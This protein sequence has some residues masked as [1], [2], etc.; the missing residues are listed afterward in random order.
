VDDPR[1]VRGADRAQ[2]LEHDG[3]QRLEGQ[4]PVALEAVAQRLALQ[5]VHDHDRRAVGQLDDVAD[6]DDVGVRHHG[7]RA[8]L[9]HEALAYDLIRRP[10]CPEHLERHGLARDGVRGR[11][12]DAHAALAE[13]A[14][15]DESTRDDG[16]GG[17]LHDPLD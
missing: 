13:L 2:H 14:I 12:D 1:G 15:E 6:L 16:S 8:R 5:E 3:R 7:G 11:P 9:A 10:V 4:R 17:E